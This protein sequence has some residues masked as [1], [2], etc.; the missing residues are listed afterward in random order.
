MA[1][2]REASVRCVFCHEVVPVP[3]E[4]REALDVV[5]REVTADA[6]TAEAFRRLGKPPSVLLRF[7]DGF[8]SN[9]VGLV[10]VTGFAFRGAVSF[11]DWILDKSSSWFR[12]NAWDWLSGPEQTLVV[13]GST[14]L[15]VA[16][17]YALG[18]FGR[19]RAIESPEAAQGDGG[20][21][22]DAAGRTGA[23]P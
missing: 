1:I 6:L 5:E 20:A 17:V 12:V 22:A 19:R 8:S 4:Y 9:V 21:S 16:A 11:F 23:L 2:G 7:I 14:L 13:Y 15:L 10:F 18:A 3:A